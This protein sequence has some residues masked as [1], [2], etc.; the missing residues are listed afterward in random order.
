MKLKQPTI[1]KGKQ[2]DLLIE[3]GEITNTVLKHMGD[4]C[5]VGKSLIDIDTI[6]KEFLESIG[7]ESACYNYRGFPR[8]SC[9]SVDDVVLHGIPNET[10]IKEGMVINI[11]CPVKYKNF[12]TDSTI[13][14]EV[15][16]VDEEKRTLNRIAYECLMETISMVKPGIKIKEICRFQEHYASKNNYKVIKTFRGHG[17]GLNLHEPPSIPYF[18]DE[19]NIYNEY[20]IKEGNVFTIEPLLVLIDD[21]ILDED[22]WS[23]KTKDGSFGTYWEH[24]LLVTNNGVKILT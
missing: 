23:Y 22:N 17:I 4:A 9:I 16:V 21:L 19:Y 13:N 12:Y 18:Y 15:G 10:V 14:I 24:T 1:Y 11:D 20:E 8:Y 2:I 7:A 3:C 5:V 6:G